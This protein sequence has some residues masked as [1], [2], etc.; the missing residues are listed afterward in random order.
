MFEDR[1]TAWSRILEEI[2]TFQTGIR[3]LPVS[4]PTMPGR[5]RKQVTS[6]FDLQAPVRLDELIQRVSNLLRTYAVHVTHP[7][8]FG[9]FNPSVTDAGIA[10]DTLAA[11]YNPQLAG[12]SHSPA[13]NELERLTLR[14]LATALGLDP[15]GVLANFTTGGAEANLSAVL[16][17]LAH[18][19]PAAADKVSERSKHGPS[20]TLRARVIIRS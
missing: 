9:L 18:H 1:M 20:S 14:Y 16:V 5:V 17:A 13:A 6:A 11:L 15:D 19:Y 8:Y 12:W 7:R 3:A 2:R 10:A 4:R